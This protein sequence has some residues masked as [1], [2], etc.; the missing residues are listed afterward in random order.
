MLW[1]WEGMLIQSGWSAWPSLY[2][3]AGGKQ[4][5]T[6]LPGAASCPRKGRTPLG[7]S[8]PIPTAIFGCTVCSL[9]LLHEKQMLVPQP[10]KP[11][12]AL[13]W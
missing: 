12:P 4:G 1:G 3:A 5:A 2:R 11:R 13:H 10:H 9:R 8:H 7:W 6:L